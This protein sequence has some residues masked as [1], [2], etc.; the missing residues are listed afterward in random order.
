MA[1]LAGAA[2][3][4]AADARLENYVKSERARGG[5]R[6]ANA[7]KVLADF[8]AEEK[9]AQ[10]VHYAVPAMS[11]VQRL[12]F[13]YPA[14][15]RAGGTVI[16]KAARDEY[17]PGSFVVLGLE[18]LGK[19]DF[20]VNDLRAKD[21]TVFPRKNL[22]LTVI[23]VWIQD[24]NAWFCYFGD[25]GKK[26]VP[27]LLLHDEDLI[28]VDEEKLDNYARVTPPG[29]P[30][31]E[32]WLTAPREVSSAFVGHWRNH[33]DFSPM[34]PGFA[35]AREIQPVSVE[36]GRFKQFFLTAH[37]AKDQKAGDY[38]G[39]IDINSK[40]QRV[41]SVP[42]KLTVLP[43]VL[44]APRTYA[45][46]KVPFLTSSYSYLSRNLIACENGGDFDLMRRQFVKILADQ[47]A[48]GQDMHMIRGNC[49]TE[50]LMTINV[51]NEAG[52]RRDTY[53]GG[54]FPAGGSSASMEDA[55]FLKRSWADATVGHHN[56]Y[57]GYGDEPGVNW[58]LSQRD[59]F[60]AYKKADFKFFIAATACLY[61]TSGWLWDWNNSSQ[62]PREDT[63]P[64]LWGTQPGAKN[65]WYASQHVGAENP[66][67]NRR[68]NGLLQYL[69]GYTCTCN[70]AHHLGY[71]ND[72]ST[73][74]R[75]MVFAYGQY[76][77]VIDTLQWE[78]FREG[79]DDIRY[80]SLLKML[81]DEAVTYDDFET[82]TAGR[83]ALHWFSTL[84]KEE[85]DQNTAR[86]EMIRM[87]ADLL[88]RGM[89]RKLPEK[90]LNQ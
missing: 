9:V 19:C 1:A 87:I 28:R 44:P 55:A 26:L 73:T 82:V 6:A 36:A 14:D 24:E 85:A 69:N 89:G 47:V 45:D 21:G 51:M 81:A 61:Y 71:F 4:L 22:D 13:A 18:N 77:G 2:T 58:I 86:L 34:A 35:D 15:G 90:E 30:A 20:R 56:F 42:V 50:T 39:S 54:M 46:T 59:L 48:H 78:G 76:D 67:F 64:R 84:K 63:F 16:I 11:S 3:V 62:D 88:N 49:D 80:A 5:E 29:K 60:K 32:H 57:M 74:Y 37:V 70:Y 52:M 41:A 43:F 10:A 12:P 33:E 53:Q 40:G 8:S 7:D 65:G 68:Q 75:E 66:D 17:E 72:D 27:E 38:F 83:K 23:K 25:R 31:Y 79:I